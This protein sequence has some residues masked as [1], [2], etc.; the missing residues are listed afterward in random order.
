[1]FAS[2]IT[3]LIFVCNFLGL[4]V[5][6]IGVLF[7][8]ETRTRLTQAQYQSLLQQ[9]ELVANLIVVYTT[10]PMDPEPWIRP[11]EARQALR[12]LAPL[13]RR[14]GQQSG[15]RIRIFDADGAV[16]ADTDVLA[17]RVDVR[18]LPPPNESVVSRSIRALGQGLAGVENWRI[19]PWRP[20]ISI[21]AARQAALR[22]ETAQGQALNERNRRVVMV[23][24]PIQRV[25]GVL[26][27][28][29]M[30]SADVERILMAERLALLPFVLA[31]AIVT[32]LASTLLALII[33]NPLRRL[34]A[35][36][37]RLRTTGATRLRLPELTNRK[38]EIGDLASSLEAMTAA[39]AGRIDLNERFA[40]DVSHEIKNPLASIR[41]AVDT[42]R[43]VKDPAQQ[44]KLL[45]IV[46]ADAN[47]LDRLVTDIARATRLDAETARTHFERV[48]LARLA[49]DIVS[50]YE[51]FPHDATEVTVR[52]DAPVVADAVVLG[53][54]GP[55]GQVLRNLIDNA[56]SFSP[57]GGVVRVAVTTQRRRDGGFARVSVEDQGPGVPPENLE[58][59]FA[60]F[61]TDRP[62]GAAFGGNSGLGLSIARQIVEAHKGRIWAENVSGPLKSDGARLIFELPVAP[63]PRT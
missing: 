57:Q 48:D 52:F 24:R 25:Q 18:E 51:H 6:F 10:R 38:D 58:T 31:A 17:G 21:E 40:A 30:E 1:L 41:S 61:Y 60:R 20:T 28:L 7:L 33:A 22:G 50:A 32:S 53:Q 12:T 19:T 3:R 35:A 46:A 26:G 63:G 45:S 43:A 54:G 27:F 23:S 14:D 56:R 29:V 34:A 42:M 15:L 16:V 36:A 11:V 4:F 2:R 8:S 55:L 62:K 5:L 47:R 39:L 9:G 13:Q 59:I 49:S 44:A 37:D